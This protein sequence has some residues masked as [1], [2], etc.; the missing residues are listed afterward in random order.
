MTSVCR[1]LP[2]RQTQRQNGQTMADDTAPWTVKSVPVAVREKAVRYA[3]MDGSTMAEWLTKAVETQAA[4]QDGTQVIPPDK[5]E[6]TQANGELVGTVALGE[7]AAALQAM[8]AAATA[9]LPISKAATR[10]VVAAIRSQVRVSRGLPARQTRL[11]IGQTI[12]SEQGDS[13]ATG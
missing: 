13:E 10:D 6:P 11:K 9:G 7:A 5:L 12:S 4:K 8:A 2:A 3:R 1:G